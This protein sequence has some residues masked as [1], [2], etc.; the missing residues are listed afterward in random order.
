MRWEKGRRRRHDL[1]WETWR[2]RAHQ[3]REGEPPWSEVWLERGKNFIGREK[4]TLGDFF[5][6]DWRFWRPQVS[7]AGKKTAKVFWQNPVAG[8]H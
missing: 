8:G 6:A 2:R 3:R 4:G 5:V 7:V 1:V